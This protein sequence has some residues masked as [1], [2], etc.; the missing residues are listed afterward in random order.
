MWV[1]EVR[2]NAQAGRVEQQYIARARCAQEGPRKRK[3]PCSFGRF[4]AV[5]TATHKTRQFAQDNRRASELHR[6]MNVNEWAL[7]DESL[8]AIREPAPQRL[9]SVCDNPQIRT[10]GAKAALISRQHG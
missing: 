7:D 10:S 8:C 2:R 6:A 1:A 9:K 5:E 4:V 3:K